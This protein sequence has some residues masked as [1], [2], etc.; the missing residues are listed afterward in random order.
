M[1]L[2]IVDCEFNQGPV[3]KLIQIGY[4]IAN[5]RSGQIILERSLYIDPFEPITQDIVELTGI[6]DEIIKQ[7]GMSLSDA[8]YVIKEDKK[9]L[10]F[11]A[12]VCQWGGHGEVGDIQAI[13]REL[14]ISWDDFPFSR[15]VVD[16]KRIFM[17]YKAFAG[18][19]SKKGLFGACEDL[20]LVFEGRQHDA[21][22]DAKN[23]FFVLKTMMDK[24]TKMDSIEQ[25][26]E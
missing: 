3:P 13:R 26:L 21:L 17:A 16:V 4:V 23:T 12:M 22:N 24:M 6:T 2:M 7:K 20:G 11:S 15:G 8:Y 14:G 9:K 1:K 25:F 5:A 19:K 18:G 10:E